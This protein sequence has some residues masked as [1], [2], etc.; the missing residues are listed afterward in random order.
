M[1]RLT[2]INHVP[3]VLN[4]DLIEHVE[5][6]PDTVIAMTSGQK[7]MVRESAEEV[8]QKVI[9]FRRSITGMPE[10]VVTSGEEAPTD[11]GEE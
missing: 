6:T 5:V 8:I 1:I 9:D 11:G 7:F 3:L 10:T 4:S 2:R